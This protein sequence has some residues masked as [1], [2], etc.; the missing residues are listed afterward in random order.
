MTDLELARTRPFAQFRKNSGQ[1]NHFVITAL[2]GLDEV[3]SGRARKQ[4]EFSTSWNP[5]DHAASASRS[6]DYVIRTSLGWVTDLLHVYWREVSL[7]PGITTSTER[8]AIDGHHD[9]GES[10]RLLRFSR[11]LGLR[12][13]PEVRLAQLAVH[14][15]NRV[16]HSSASGGLDGDVRG[17]LRSAAQVYFEE[18]SGTD[19]DE[20]LEHEAGGHSPTFKEVLSMMTSCHR[21]A[22]A[23]DAAVLGRINLVEYADRCLRSH[24]TGEGERLA[25]D[26]SQSLWGGG[27]TLAQKRLRHLLGQYG[28]REA[29]EAAENTLPGGVVDEFAAL[30]VTEARARFV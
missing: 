11:H 24:L 27:V 21:L 12:D 2:V 20:M 28:F 25:I 22:Q 13:S 16:I 6:R 3:K 14:W 18:Y 1:N 4:P 7:L 5:K 29:A 30:S 9:D 8:R 15:R 17:A 23:F 10:K 19:I 26:R